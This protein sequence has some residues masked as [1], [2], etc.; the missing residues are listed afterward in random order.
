MGYKQISVSIDPEMMKRLKPVLERNGW[1]IASFLRKSVID[2]VED[3]E[4][5]QA[6]RTQINPDIFPDAS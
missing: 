4:A 1:T 6:G 2:A 5:I 3:Y